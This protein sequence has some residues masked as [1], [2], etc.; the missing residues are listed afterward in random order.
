[1]ESTSAARHAHRS[2]WVLGYLGAM[3]SKLHETNAVGISQPLGLVF[4]ACSLCDFESTW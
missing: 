4:L 2:L 1:M 3:D